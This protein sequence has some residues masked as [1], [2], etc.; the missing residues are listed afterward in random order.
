MGQLVDVISV[1]DVLAEARA[2]IAL[3]AECTEALTRAE[4]DALFA[5]G[6]SV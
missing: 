5:A 2:R 6:D 3:E 1:P 4:G